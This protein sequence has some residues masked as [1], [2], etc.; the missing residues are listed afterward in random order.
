MRVDRNL[1]CELI[2]RADMTRPTEELVAE[3]T[4]VLNLNQPS[5]R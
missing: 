2:E 4:E 5:R 3:F 1:L